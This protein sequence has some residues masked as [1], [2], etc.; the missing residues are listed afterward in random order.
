[1]NAKNKRL[2]SILLSFTIGA[3]A[4]GCARQSI[5]SNDKESTSVVSEYESSLNAKD[6]STK[7]TTTTKSDTT[8]ATE[9]TTKEKETKVTTSNQA[10]EKEKTFY[11]DEGNICVTSNVN[12]REKPNT[13]S[14]V[15]TVIN[16]FEKLKRIK[17]NDSW[18][19]VSYGDKKGY[20]S[21]K[22]T[23]ELGDTFVEVDISEQ[24][25]YLY[26]DDEL[27]L[28][29]DVVTG[30]KNK[31]DTRLGCNPI[32]AKQT[33]RYL[34]GDDYNVHVDFWLPFDKGQGLHDAS[35]RKTFDDD[36]YLNGS[37]GC[38]NMKYADAKTVYENV[39]VGTK[40]LVHK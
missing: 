12:L 7:K 11:E 35:W 8:S 23:K 24:N 40:V 31:Y 17:T 33:D 13:K 16:K 4:C 38:V 3:S 26:V 22:Y 2:L 29:A 37:H 19:Y 1:M 6:E 34:K 32:Y 10:D 20:V 28:T 15:I 21:K 25:L 18:D 27:Y 30:R 36:D 5:L 39:S 9:S 14:K